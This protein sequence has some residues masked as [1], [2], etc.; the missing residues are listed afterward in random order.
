M[1]KKQ[2]IDSEFALKVLKHDQ[3]QPRSIYSVMAGDAGLVYGSVLGG[4]RL[5]YVEFLSNEFGLAILDTKPSASTLWKLTAAQ[6]V[7]FSTLDDHLGFFILVAFLRSL[8][9][10]KT[11]GLFLRPQSCL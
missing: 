3:S 2:P 1:Q 6:R 7:L 5:S 10:R 11:A 8:I 9:G 4:H